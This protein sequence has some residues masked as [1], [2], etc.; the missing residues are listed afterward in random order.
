MDIN[1]LTKEQLIEL[2]YK[3]NEK[4]KE[5]ENKIEILEAKNRDLN[6]KLDKLIEKY[7]NKALI[8]KKITADIYCKKTEK[9]N[10]S[11]KAINEVA[12]KEK[13]QRKTPTENFINDLKQLVSEVIIDD[14]D[15]LSNGIDRKDVKEFGASEMYKIESSSSSFKVVKIVRP[16]YKDKNHIYQSLVNDPFPHSPLTPSLS[17]NLIIMKY[18]LFVPLYRYS[19]YL[20]TIGIKIPVENLYNYIERTMKILEPLY[21]KL[22]EELLA[23][24]AKVIHAD[25]TSLE[26]IDSPKDL[27]YMFVYTTSFWDK[28]IYIYEFSENR[29]TKK[30]AVHLKNY[31]GYLVT[32]GYSGYNVFDKVQRCFVHVRRNFYDCLKPLKEKDRKNSQ[33]YKVIELTNKIF[34]YEAEFKNSKLTAGEIKNRRNS[35]KYVAILKELDTY[36]MSLAE[37]KNQLLIK[38]VKYYINMRRELYTFLED[39]HVDISNNLAERTVKPFVIARKN[40][41]FCKT[42]D[43]AMTVGKVFSIVQTARANGL[44]VEEYIKYVIENINCKNIDDILPWSDKLPSN[45]RIV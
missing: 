40:F 11:E 31:N 17:A 3:L 43:G 33:A 35:S 34:K 13:K 12:P 15:F 18:Q 28:P 26:V 1:S 5:Q 42:I 41:M 6:I 21:N 16:K 8:N 38:A 23:N 45:I 39:G 32:D 19:E 24:N 9:T 20:R 7:E 22:L 37:T 4:S 36:I 29:T 44:N 10:V 2:V 27:C 30:L 14:F 25:E